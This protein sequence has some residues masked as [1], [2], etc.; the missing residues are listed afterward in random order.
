MRPYQLMCIV[1]RIGAGRKTDMGQPGLTAVLKEM[2]ENPAVPIMLRCNVESGYKYQNP[3]RG[4]D[5]PGGELF[6]DKRDLDILQKMGLVPGAVR[7]ALD[8]LECLLEAVPASEG[9]CGRSE[10]AAGMWQGCSEAGS[11][12]YEQ[13]RAKGLG[14]IINPRR[15]KEMAMVKKKSVKAMYEADTLRLRPHHLMCMACF[16]GGKKDLA[17]I[18]EDNLFEA[19]DIVQKNPDIPVELISGCCMICQPCRLY[20]ATSNACVGGRSMNLRDQKKDLDVLCRLGLRYGDRLPARRLYRLL[21]ER[22]C[23]TTEICG[24]G[25]GVERAPEWRVCGE[26]E[27]KDA[28]L[29]ARAAG[30]G[31]DDV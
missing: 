9:I 7:P 2:R 18:A 8:L 30:L 20:H 31:L 29:K 1:C 23:S 5:T 22:V 10:G 15:L 27:G 24:Y 13:G 19:I 6:N 11:G 21:F 17:P 16:H 26:K 25:D 14:A 28:Y 12:R 3:G 4:D